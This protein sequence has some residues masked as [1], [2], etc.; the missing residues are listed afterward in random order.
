MYGKIRVAL[1]EKTSS[2]KS[3][4]ILARWQKF[5]LAKLFPDEIIEFSR[6]KVTKFPYFSYK[7]SIQCTNLR[8][9]VNSSTAVQ[10][11]GQGLFPSFLCYQ[12]CS[13][14]IEIHWTM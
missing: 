11:L 5:S 2:G 7:C 8:V 14:E 4:E 12:L 9:D 3:D 1:L 10:I 6:G 13:T